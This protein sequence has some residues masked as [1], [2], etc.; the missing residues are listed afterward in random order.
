MSI[1]LIFLIY[2]YSKLLRALLALRIL[3]VRLKHCNIY[4]FTYFKYIVCIFRIPYIEHKYK[5]S[6][7]LK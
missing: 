1:F 2:Y 5:T 7:R 6:Q 3:N 4:I